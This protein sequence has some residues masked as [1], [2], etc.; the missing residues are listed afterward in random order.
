MKTLKWIGVVVLVLGGLLALLAIF[1]ATLPVKHTATRSASLKATPQQVWDV[2]SGPPNWRPE[3]TRYEELSPVE[4]RRRWTEYGKGGSNMTYEVVESTP[5]QT[6]VTRIAD[7]HL[8][9]GGT[10]TYAIAPSVDGGSTLT[11]TE[12]GE[13]YNPIFRFISRYVM[14]YTATMD[15]YLDAL[16]KKIS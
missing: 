3:V 5:P 6:L 1:G 13:V 10:W 15:R 14:G 8:P 7:P 9:F 4:G 11:I 12:N 16:H 2:I